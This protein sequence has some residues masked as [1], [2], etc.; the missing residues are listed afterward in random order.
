M[1]TFSLTPWK[2]EC[3]LSSH[4]SHIF[5]RNCILPTFTGKIIFTSNLP[6]NRWSGKKSQFP[7]LL[8]MTRDKQDETEQSRHARDTP[9][10]TS[11]SWR[12]PYDCASGCKNPLCLL[13]QKLKPDTYKKTAGNKNPAI[14]AGRKGGP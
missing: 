7:S 3:M 6:V 14:R 10:L 11:L 13:D 2:K 12:E 1:Q 8:G 5:L 4:F 9:T